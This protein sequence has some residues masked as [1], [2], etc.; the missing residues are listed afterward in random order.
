MACNNCFYTLTP[1]LLRECNLRW[2]A[3]N[4]HSFFHRYFLYH[5]VLQLHPCLLLD[6]CNLRLTDKKVPPFSTVTACTICFYTLTPFLLRECNLRWADT[7]CTFFHRYI[8]YH[9]FYTLTP[10][11]LRESNLR[12]SDT[13]SQYFSTLLAYTICFARLHPCYCQR[14]I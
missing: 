12:W 7:S 11:I 13:K 6:E 4:V 14:E 1:L 3:K 8:L 5:L 2:A 9:L 10:L